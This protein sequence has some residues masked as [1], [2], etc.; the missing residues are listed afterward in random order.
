MKITDIY[1]I[2]NKIG[3]GAFGSVYQIYHK[4]LGLTRA[5]KIFKKEEGNNNNSS[6]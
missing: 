5:L 1:Q 2:G 4:K 6:E 3:S